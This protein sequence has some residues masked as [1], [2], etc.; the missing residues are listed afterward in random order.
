VWPRLPIPIGQRKVPRYLCTNAI[1]SS[2][3]YIAY[4]VIIIF[5]MRH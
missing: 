2:V 4:I 1:Q 5:V 3:C